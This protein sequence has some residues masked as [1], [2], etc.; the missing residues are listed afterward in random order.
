MQLW[1][2]TQFCVRFRISV[3]TFD[4]NSADKSSE[5][6]FDIGLEL[7]HEGKI[8]IKNARTIRVKRDMAFIDFC[9]F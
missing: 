2:L 6:L 4:F 8:S 5:K 3:E 9:F 7:W 1:A